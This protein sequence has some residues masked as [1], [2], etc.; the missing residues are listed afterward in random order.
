MD[1][2]YH[3]IYGSSSFLLYRKSLYSKSKQASLPRC[4]A[5]GEEVY[6]IYDNVVITS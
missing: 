1:W 4:A 2:N 5:R 3:G 6:F